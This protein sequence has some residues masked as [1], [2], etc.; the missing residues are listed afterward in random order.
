MEHKM[1][2]HKQV[3]EFNPE[4]GSVI[5]IG[6][7]DGIHLG[8]RTILKKVVNEARVRDL[9]A[10]LLTFFPH[11]RMVVQK[12][13]DLK[14]LNTLD[15]KIQLLEVLGVDHLVIQPFTQE[16]SR[17]TALEYVRDLLVN[18]L[19]A[20]KIIIGYDVRLESI[21]LADAL[22]KGLTDSG[23]DII[24]I[25]LCGTEEVYFHIKSKCMFYNTSFCKLSVISVGHFNTCKCNR[26][27][28]NF[29]HLINHFHGNGV[30]GLEI[31]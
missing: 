29:T 17:L 12:Q 13:T 23:V 28:S 15:E 21:E 4:R 20:K 7:F 22:I 19:Q 30:F 14:L 9:N 18:Q 16:F 2:V 27:V 10:V 11:P 5:T 3:Q 25:G 31:W 24:N 1:Q 26:N 6:T 8:H